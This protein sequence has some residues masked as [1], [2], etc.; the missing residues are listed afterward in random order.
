MLQ[1]LN[2]TEIVRGFQKRIIVFMFSKKTSIEFEGVVSI[3]NTSYLKKML[4]KLEVPPHVNTL[5]FEA[6][7]MV[8]ARLKVKM[9]ELIKLHKEDQ[10]GK[11]EASKQQQSGRSYNICSY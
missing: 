1:T 2:D 11:K 5:E 9:E 8:K 3:N 6:R 7:D 4:K 10:K